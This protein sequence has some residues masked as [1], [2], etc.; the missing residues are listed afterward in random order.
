MKQIR[1]R[2]TYANVMASIAVFLVLGGATALAAGL[3]KNS[4][5]SKQIKKGAV[6]EAKIKDG[7]V[8]AGKLADGSVITAK[9]AD[10]SV[11]TG[12]IVNGAVTSDKLADGSVGTGKLGNS[13]VTTGKLANDAVTNPKIANDAVTSTKIAADSVGSSEIVPGVVGAEELE[14]IHEHFGP[15]TEITDVTAHDGSYA[16]QS[17][18]VS[19][20]A[21]EDLLSVSVDWTATAGHNERNFAG[22]SITRG[23][24]DSATVEVDF[25][26]GASV[27]KFRPVATCIF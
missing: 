2:L 23:A 15:E 4:V 11:I 7:A 24:T 25:D 19:C 5:G 21:G 17:A 10:G 26:G 3:A 6:T 20:G 18:T 27:A 12:K 9:L 13:A 8:S 16:T 14:T 22:A 1:K